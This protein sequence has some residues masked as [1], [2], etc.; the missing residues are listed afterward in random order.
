L[1]VAG[2]GGGAGGYTTGSGGAG[3]GLTAGNGTGTNWPA[4]NGRGGSPSAGGAAGAVCGMP[5]AGSLGVGGYGRGC[6]HGGGGGGGGYY[7]GGGGDIEPGGGGSSF[8]NATYGASI[9]HSQGVQNSDGQ[10]IISYQDAVDLIAPTFNSSTTFTASEN[11]ANT[12]TAATIRI[13]ESATITISSG[14]DAS[15][16]NIYVSDTD[17]AIIKFKASPDFEA[18]ADVGSNNVYEIT[19]TATD[20][21]S[22]SGSQS[23]TITVTDVVDTSAFN[24]FNL[25]GNVTTATYRETIQITANVTV[26]SKVTFKVNNVRIPGCFNLR[27][28]GTSPSIIATCNWKASRRGNLTLTA[29]ATPTGAGITGATATPLKVFVTNRSGTR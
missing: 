24:S 18:P 19:L 29:T 27:T 4:G 22:N 3:G 15:L 14:L 1:I 21:S 16:F 10:I 8:A 25:A 2:G 11:L 17:T 6:S 23:I 26:A 12:A 28:T 20:G 9:V 13:S 7:G 5:S